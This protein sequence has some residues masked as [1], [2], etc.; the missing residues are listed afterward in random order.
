M[1]TKQV[2]MRACGRVTAVLMAVTLDAWVAVQAM[3]L[4]ERFDMWAKDVM[5][6]AAAGASA[7]KRVI[8]QLLPAISITGF[9]DNLGRN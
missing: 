7:W 2:M 1:R 4:A 9:A 5:F 3:L 8:S 6:D